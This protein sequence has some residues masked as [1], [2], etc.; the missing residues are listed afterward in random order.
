MLLISVT[1][2]CASFLSDGTCSKGNS[3]VM[4]VTAVLLFCYCQW[5]IMALAQFDFLKQLNV[6]HESY[7]SDDYS[8]QLNILYF[9]FQLLDVLT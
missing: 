8:T 6:S 1:F 7:H 5:Y 4:H 3:F 2:N 9:S